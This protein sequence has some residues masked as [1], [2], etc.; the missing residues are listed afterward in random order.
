[1]NMKISAARAAA[2][3]MV[4]SLTI[5]A[6]TSC[7]APPENI[8]TVLSPQGSVAKAKDLAPRLDALEGKKI[9]MWFSATPDQ[10]Y[11][12]KGAV[13]FDELSGML[14]KEFPGIQIVSYDKLP[15]KFAPTDE[16]VEAITGV[17]PDGVVIGFGG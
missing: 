7:T 16:I 10:F 17:Q 11:A 4:L 1:M 12:G 9:A 3:I 13:L 5:A 8:L 6:F 14:Q 2:A 15:M